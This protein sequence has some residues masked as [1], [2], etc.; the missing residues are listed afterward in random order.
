MA[1]RS[2][3]VLQV[4]SRNAAFQ[5]WQSL[6]TNRNKRQR[7]GEF[8]IQGVRP[9]TLALAHGWEL[10]ALLVSDSGRRS[11][12]A[13][14]VLADGRAERVYELSAELMSELGQKDEQSPELL[15][16]AA[17]PADD[18]ARIPV[19]ED[20]LVVAFDRPSS[21][22]NLGTVIRSADALGACGV[23]VT[24]H[25]VDLYDPKTLRAS[26][27]SLFAMPAARIDSST[28][29]FAWVDEV[30]ARGIELRVVGTSEDGD[31]DLPQC[32]LAGPTLLV[33]GNETA[34]MSA[35]WA[36]RCDQTARIPMV[37]AASSLNASASASI[38]LYEAACQRAAA[39]NR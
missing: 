17:L 7:L 39:N 1:Q 11:E 8:L 13:A 2:T 27:G 29:V 9:I 28:Q 20:M 37:G 6:L 16:V 34:G 26:T 32:E 21:P 31:V 3:K 5:Q 36:A 22:G 12:W 24:G 19:R 25:A 15:A 18:L 35:A 10:T 14:G 23:V 38:A 30:R 4:T 33:I